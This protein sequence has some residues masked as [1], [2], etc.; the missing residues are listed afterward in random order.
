MS[1]EDS[2]SDAEAPPSKRA[3]ASREEDLYVSMDEWEEL[4]QRCKTLE[5]NFSDLHK[6]F[7]NEIS[8]MFAK[9]M[10]A[11]IPKIMSKAIVQSVQQEEAQA[12]VDKYLSSLANT[13]Q[14]VVAPTLQD[15][16]Q[17]S[18]QNAING[19]VEEAFKK[20]LQEEV[21][22]FRCSNHCLNVVLG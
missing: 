6:R 8:P 18:L 20:K 17:K 11:E 9:V 21:R 16:V 3:K 10:Q 5:D 2:N 7:D 15:V 13:V 14:N 1:A 19:A 12:V 22:S 4:S